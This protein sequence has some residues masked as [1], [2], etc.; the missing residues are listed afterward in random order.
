MLVFNFFKG[1]LIDCRDYVWNKVRT[2]KTAIT[3]LVVSLLSFDS[4]LVRVSTITAITSTPTNGLQ[5]LQFVGVDLWVAMGNRANNIELASRVSQQQYS[6]T[7]H[8]HSKFKVTWHFH[9]HSWRSMCAEWQVISSHYELSACQ[10]V[11][12]ISPF[13]GQ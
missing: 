2:R 10:I 7:A 9:L 13:P 3:T 1:R 11:V 6:Y 8:I 4:F 12:K 5:G